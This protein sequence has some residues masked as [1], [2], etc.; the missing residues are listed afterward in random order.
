M[1]FVSYIRQPRAAMQ[2]LLLYPGSKKAFY[3]YFIASFLLII[4]L[5]FFPFSQ[6]SDYFYQ[7]LSFKQPAI[8]LTF[9]GL[10]SLFFSLLA[11]VNLIVAYFTALIVSKNI[12]KIDPDLLFQRFLLGYSELILFSALPQGLAW[13]NL[14]HLDLIFTVLSWAAQLY[15]LYLAYL[16]ITTALNL[17]K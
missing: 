3:N 4:G 13:L 2:K 14:F 8:I 16:M 7:I 5:M 15:A 10:F 12:T 1:S 6:S 9:L 17:F 11:V